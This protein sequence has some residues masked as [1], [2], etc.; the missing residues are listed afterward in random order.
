M[1]PNEVSL[2]MN[3][4][5]LKRSFRYKTLSCDTSLGSS[6]VDYFRLRRCSNSRLEGKRSKRKSSR[7]A[8]KFIEMYGNLHE[9]VRIG[10]NSYEFVKTSDNS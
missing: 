3:I 5:L 7:K 6:Q 10:E 2:S 9:D 1:L 4:K 8:A